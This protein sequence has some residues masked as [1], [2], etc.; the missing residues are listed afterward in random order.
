MTS[1]LKMTFIL[2][3]GFSLLMGTATSFAQQR[4]QTVFQPTK[5]NVRCQDDSL[6]NEQASKRVEWAKAN[7]VLPKRDIRDML[8][9]VS[10]DMKVVK[11]NRIQYPMFA[12]W[13]GNPKEAVLWRPE[14]H[15]WPKKLPDNVQW[16]AVC[17]ASCYTS[18]QQLLTSVGYMPIWEAEKNQVQ[19]IMVVSRESAV[20]NITTTPAALGKYTKSYRDTDHK[21]MTFGTAG[22]GSISV[23]KGHVLVNGQG[24]LK[25]ASSFKAGDSLLTEEGQSDEITSI[26]EEDY[27]GSVYNVR[28]KSLKHDENLVIV[29]GFVN[30]SDRFQNDWADSVGKTILMNFIP[31]DI[32]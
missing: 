18:D 12:I 6:T 7:N 14:D 21:I 23:T 32:F 4:K 20:G 9:T 3:A 10:E 5:S 22:G 26:V 24:V 15:N 28:P 29:Q 8:Y 25:V 19:E 30:G 2:A 17:T 27:F 1:K 13:N 31:N 16:L 11:R